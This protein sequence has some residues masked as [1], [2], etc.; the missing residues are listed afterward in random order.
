MADHIS[1]I[2]AILVQVI[3]KAKPL[4]QVLLVLRSWRTHYGLRLCGI[5]SKSSLPNEA[6]TP[7]IGISSAPTIHFDA[8]AYIYFVR[9]H[10]ITARKW[11]MWLFTSDRPCSAR[12]GKHK[13]HQ[14]TFVHKHGECRTVASPDDSMCPGALK[15]P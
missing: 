9:M 14:N 5:R 8:L 13:C 10:S 11:S 3:G 6:S 1:V 4:A 15:I 12:I 7:K 2:I